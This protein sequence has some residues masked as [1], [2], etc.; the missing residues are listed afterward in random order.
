[1]YLIHD[2]G[3]RLNQAAVLLSHKAVP[4]LLLLQGLLV[5][6]PQELHVV[7]NVILWTHRI[8]SQNRT[9]VALVAFIAA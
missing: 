5:A 9:G 8:P 4:P 7:A 1:M 3:N 6:R 2:V